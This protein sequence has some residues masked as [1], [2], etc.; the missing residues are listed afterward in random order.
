[1]FSIGAFLLIV[2]LGHF[3][4]N[5]YP[6]FNLSRF[7]IIAAA[8]AFLLIVISLLTQKRGFFLII[9]LIFSFF[10]TSL[11]NP[12]YKGLVIITNSDLAKSVRNVEGLNKT[13]RWVVYDNIYLDNYIIANKANSL[14]GSYLYPQLDLWRSLDKDNK[15]SEVYNKYAHV[16]FNESSTNSEIEFVSAHQDAFIIRIDPCHKTLEKLNVR[17]FIFNK[18]ISYTCLKQKEV[19]IFPKQSIFIYERAY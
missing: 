14:S 17:Y 19:I 18:K 7:Q 1:M 6:N 10:S 2:Y 12:L 3:L 5:T 15:Y 13:S 4:V 9:L 8:T 11:A 16:V